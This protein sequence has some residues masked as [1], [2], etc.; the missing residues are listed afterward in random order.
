MTAD[1]Q[2]DRERVVAIDHAIE[3]AIAARKLPGAVYHLERGAAR[4]QRGYGKLSYEED[5]AAVRPDTV[6]DVASLS[7][8]LVTAPAVLM[9]AE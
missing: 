7:K 4:Y 2:F 8:V 1:Q 9:L 5:A 6:F 3:S